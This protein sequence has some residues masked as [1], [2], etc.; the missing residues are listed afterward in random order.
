MVLQPRLSVSQTQSLALTP[1][2]RASI[3]LLQLSVQD[4]E[5]YV[6]KKA[7]ENP[8]LSRVEAPLASGRTTSPGSSYD[9]LAE[10]VAESQSLVAH[11]IEQ[12]ALLFTD[13]TDARLAGR[14]IEELDAAGYIR[15]S[16]EEVA[17]A[18]DV[19]PERAYAVLRRLQSLEPSGLFARDLRECLALQLAAKGRLTGFMQDLLEGLDVL[20]SQGPQGLASQL[21][22]ASER[23]ERA[24]REIRRLDPK[25]GLCFETTTLAP[26]VPDLLVSADAK[27]RLQIAINPETVPRIR[28]DRAVQSSLLPRLRTRAERGYLSEQA[29]EVAWLRRALQRRFE[30]L[31]RVGQA[32]LAHQGD[33]FLR[34]PA[35][36]K[37]LTRRNLAD[38]LDLS[39]ATISR[40]VANK[41]LTSLRGTEPL[42]RFFSAALG[43]SGDISAA[44]AQERLRELVASEPS[45][46]PFSDSA[47]A[48]R[49][50]D[51]GLP[52]AR[53]TVAK[54]RDLLRIPPAADRRRLNQHR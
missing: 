10:R 52:V 53:R 2:L 8:L 31:L 15:I 50:A 1:A 43:A 23:V 21:G 7:E 18:C 47:L 54:Y 32:I 46:K 51:V 13:S 37:P 14:F 5:A 16:P 49:L 26:L 33:Y 24:L 6:A 39:E 22:I 19:T 48:A 40:V 42:K 9:L 44:A 36:L 45:A 34:G 25:P 38:S 4:L 3:Q 17:E 27:G 30:T 20:A 11:L 28:L 12:A 35:A 29:Q 41:Y